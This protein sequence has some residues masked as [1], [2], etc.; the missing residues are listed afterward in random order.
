MSGVRW[1]GDKVNGTVEAAIEQFL[2]TAVLL[3]QGDAINRCPVDTGTLRASI[4]TEVKD[5]TATVGT[6]VHYAAY[7]EYGTV[8]MKAQPYLR[9]AL[10]ENK[11]EL[12]I[13]A[14][15]ILDAHI[16]GGE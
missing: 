2:E 7:V 16:G 1:F 3:V 5:K 10:D 14:Q 12:G 11:D 8:K 6:N 4:A 9:P 15:K 13:L